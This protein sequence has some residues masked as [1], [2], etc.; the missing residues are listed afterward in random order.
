MVRVYLL[1]A[2]MAAA[3][4]SGCVGGSDVG[5]SAIDGGGEREAGSGAIQG[6]VTDEEGLPV[7]GVQVTILALD[8]SVTTGPSGE[9]TFE[10]LP[11]GT[12][13]VF[14][15]KLGYESLGRMA[16]VAEDDTAVLNV[17]L[18]FI[19]VDEI[20]HVVYGP[21]SGY[22]SCAYVKPGIAHV[23]H[24]LVN[25]SW[26]G[27]CN[28]LNVNN[29][30]GEQHNVLEIEPD[31]DN[32][33]AVIGEMRWTQTA[34]GTAD[35]FALFFTHEDGYGRDWWC[36]ANGQSPIQFAYHVN[37]TKRLCD[38]EGSDPDGEPSTDHV[39]HLTAFLDFQTYDVTQPST[40]GPPNVAFQQR[41]ESIGTIYYGEDP[42]LPYTA[43]PDA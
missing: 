5:P 8:R 10:N 32:I 20:Y 21:Y 12:Y 17:V 43:F 24:S 26:S 1:A 16:T 2:A 14:F 19:E 22:V 7:E 39:L 9:Y 6:L 40:L 29:L 38:R 35:S 25:G 3:V 15:A 27:N 28:F 11:A 18:G 37:E 34:A 41:Y 23:P 33:W 13:Q 31:Q 42:V 4:L 36:Q 30:L